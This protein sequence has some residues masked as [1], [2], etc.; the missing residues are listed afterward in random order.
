[1][2]LKRTSSYRVSTTVIGRWSTQWCIGNLMGRN[3]RPTFF[4]NLLEAAARMRVDLPVH[5]SPATT[6]RTPVWWPCGW[7][8]LDEAL[9]MDNAGRRN[10]EIQNAKGVSEW[11]S[12]VKLRWSEK[13]K[14]FRETLTGDCRYWLCRTFASTVTE[15]RNLPFS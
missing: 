9:S 14:D 12:R 4:S 13:T 1:M 7:T 6:I 10:L 3:R 5:F 11:V 8:D 15:S 2:K